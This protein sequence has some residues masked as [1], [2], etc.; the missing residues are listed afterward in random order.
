VWAR[1]TGSHNQFLLVT[2]LLRC[3][4]LFGALRPAACDGAR[5]SAAAMGQRS[6]RVGAERREAVTPRERCH[7]RRTMNPFRLAPTRKPGS[8]WPALQRRV[9]A[10][11]SPMQRARDAG[12]SALAPT[13]ERGS[14]SPP[15]RRSGS[16]R[17]PCAPCQYR[18]AGM[19]IKANFFLLVTPLLRCH[20]LF[21]ALR[22]AG[23]D[24]ATRPAAAMGQRSRRVG[25]EHGEAV[26][27]RERC[28]QIESR[29]GRWHW[30]WFRR[31]A[32]AGR[33]PSAQRTLR[34]PAS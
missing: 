10:A 14:Q 11:P 12:A 18:L 3:H 17:I 9:S 29:P 33:D 20:A 15:R 24:G 13:P 16:R 30:P 22:P 21:G 28:H 25:A 4:A 2:P 32:L 27:P 1:S 19:M 23:C 34:R 7:Q 8:A 5:R 31:A 26:T 6:R